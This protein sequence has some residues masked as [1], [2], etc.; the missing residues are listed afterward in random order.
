MKAICQMNNKRESG[1][2]LI[3]ILV[4]VIIIG[5]LGA[6]AAP[7]WLSFL[8]RQKMNA[9]NSDLVSVIRDTQSDA[10]QQRSSRRLTI[11]PVG[12]IPS[13]SVSDPV[14]GNVLLTDELSS[15]AT[16]LQ[17]SAFERNSS[18]TWIAA[19]TLAFDFDHNG[20]I[21][22]ASGLPYVI[23]VQ[24]QDSSFSI[25]PKCVILTTLL[26]SIKVENGDVCNDFSA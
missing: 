2:T 21:S 25:L 6:I 24:T 4:V 20:N 5:I 13:V 19:S 1:F 7:G 12:A 23:Q 26:G 17:L 14:N 18:G 16:T 10:I 11:S 8:T 3:E 22:S 15:D 9:V